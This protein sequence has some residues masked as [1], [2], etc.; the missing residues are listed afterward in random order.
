[1]E[2]Y[3]TCLKC[4][5][6]SL[7]KEFTNVRANPDGLARWCKECLAE[8]KRLRD[9]APGKKT[10]RS[11]KYGLN[12]AAPL[13][14]YIVEACEICSQD[15]YPRGPTYKRCESCS[16]LSNK[17][18]YKSLVRYKVSNETVVEVTKKYINSHA[19]TYCGRPYSEDNPRWF[20]H[21]MPRCL[22]GSNEA[23]NIAICC[24]ECNISKAGLQLYKWKELCRLVVNHNGEQEI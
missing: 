5:K 1:M 18:V 17:I 11:S 10:Y 14:T 4:K 13:D 2:T 3:K 12:P 19:C 23:D 7:A 9:H 24:K 20:D 6:K 22:G 15:F 8:K 21:I 16:N